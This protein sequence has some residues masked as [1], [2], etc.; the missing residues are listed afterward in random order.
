MEK[1]FY[2]ARMAGD[3]FDRMGSQSSEPGISPGGH[4]AKVRHTIK[5]LAGGAEMTQDTVFHFLGDN[6]SIGAAAVKKRG[7]GFG[8]GG[9][10]LHDGL[11]GAIFQQEWYGRLSL[12]NR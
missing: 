1:P 2:G 12:E 6:L 5:Q 11:R 7:R 8:H 4:F 10:I 3:Y 9:A